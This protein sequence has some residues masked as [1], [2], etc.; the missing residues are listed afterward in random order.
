MYEATDLKRVD[1]ISNLN[2]ADL[3]PKLKTLTDNLIAKYKR[4][5]VVGSVG[6]ADA[7]KV[8]G[9][10]I[11]IMEGGKTFNGSSLSNATTIIVE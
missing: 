10:S 2:Y 4:I 8:P 9:Q 6:G 5:A 7:K 1:L 11:Y 3:S